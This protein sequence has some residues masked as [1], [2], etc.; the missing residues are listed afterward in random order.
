MKRI[1]EPQLTWNREVIRGG[2]TDN[3]EEEL[4]EQKKD[5]TVNKMKFWGFRLF[6]DGLR[7]WG[8]LKS[9]SFF[10]LSI[11]RWL[12]GGGERD[13]ISTVKILI[14]FLLLFFL[15]SSF[16]F[17]FFACCRSSKSFQEREHSRIFESLCPGIR[18]MLW[19]AKGWFMGHTKS[20]LLEINFHHKAV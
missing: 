3:D 14:F 10:Y 1:G 15:F 12:G 6:W 20:E 8:A 18:E 16:S 4:Q 11:L 19:A 9:L 2:E 13:R 7:R 17:C 5:E